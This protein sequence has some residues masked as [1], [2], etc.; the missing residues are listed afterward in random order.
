MH[1]SFGSFC[2]C[3]TVI[4]HTQTQGFPY[5]FTVRCCLKSHSRAAECGKASSKLQPQRRR[6]QSQVESVQRE[7][8]SDVGRHSENMAE[9][10][11]GR[12][13]DQHHVTD[14]YNRTTQAVLLPGRTYQ[15]HLLWSLPF[16]LRKNV[17]RV[18]TERSQD[19]LF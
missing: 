16:S 15:G 17:F 4:T 19:F 10:S 9:S 13:V 1:T 18:D 14:N 3:A 5:S 11:N 12:S 8:G 7:D 6:S 2:L